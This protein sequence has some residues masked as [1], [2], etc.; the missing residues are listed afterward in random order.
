MRN[1]AFSHLCSVCCTIIPADYL[2]GHFGAKYSDI[3]VQRIIVHYYDVNDLDH[4]RFYNMAQ[5]Q[6]VLPGRAQHAGQT[7]VSLYRGVPAAV[8][9]CRGGLGE[10][11]LS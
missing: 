6:S 9:G 1:V 10:G 4:G 2:L 11:G 8:A 3:L 5:Y 7:K